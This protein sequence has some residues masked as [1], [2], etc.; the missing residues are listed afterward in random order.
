MQV[1]DGKVRASLQGD[2]VVVHISNIQ[3]FQ[4]MSRAEASILLATILTFISEQASYLFTYGE[5]VLHSTEV[6]PLARVL[7][8]LLNR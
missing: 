7:S 4:G 2:L 1:T 5:S 8:F 3:H 6:A